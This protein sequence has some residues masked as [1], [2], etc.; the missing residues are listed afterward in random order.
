MAVGYKN[1]PTRLDAVPFYY[2]RITEDQ[3][4]FFPNPPRDINGFKNNNQ[5][6]WQMLPDSIVLNA[7]NN[8]RFDQTLLDT[9]TSGPLALQ[10]PFFVFGEGDLHFSLAAGPK[11]VVV[12]KWTHRF[13]NAAGEPLLDGD[14]NA[15]EISGSTAFIA[16]AQTG[17]LD[18]DY[19]LSELSRKIEVYPYQVPGELAAKLREINLDLTQMRIGI[20]LDLSIEAFNSAV[21]LNPVISNGR[22]INYQ[23]AL[24]VTD[25]AEGVPLA[26]GDFIPQGPTGFTANANTPVLP[27][28]G[29]DI[30][31]IGQANRR[32]SGNFDA[33]RADKRILIR[34]NGAVL[35]GLLYNVPANDRLYLYTTDDLG[36]LTIKRNDVTR[37]QVAATRSSA[38]TTLGGIRTYR[39]EFTRISISAGAAQTI[40]IDS[41]DPNVSIE[42][43]GRA[44]GDAPEDTTLS[45]VSYSSPS[46]TF[47]QGTQGSQEKLGLLRPDPDYVRPPGT[48][49]AQHKASTDGQLLVAARRETP[50]GRSNL[51]T[52]SDRYTIPEITDP[53]TFTMPADL[54]RQTI[55][56]Y[57]TGNAGGLSH[58]VAD[59]GIVI[60]EAG[61]YTVEAQDSF[62]FVSASITDDASPVQLGFVLFHWRTDAQGNDII[63]GD[64]WIDSY[65]L[66]KVRGAELAPL[67]RAVD[68]ICEVGD[69]FNLLFGFKSL[70]VGD[71]LIFTSRN[72][73]VP[74]TRIPDVDRR[75]KITKK[76]F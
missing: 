56:I 37:A 47:K 1:I 71:D 23:P 42:L 48:T 29:K 34:K 2:Q 27:S 21:D 49:E 50:E 66:A 76:Q 33:S 7:A 4:V 3:H 28:A 26:Q 11:L 20:K 64:T 67:A 9:D 36:V 68:I 45:N 39:Y 57:P 13:L 16:I 54:E 41:S 52:R 5:V 65:Q 74:G 55:F 17:I 40:E 6:F 8:H 18:I 30:L 73:F 25:F 10:T 35:D 59:K 38:T 70:T 75:M 12:H 53:M 15:I 72:T 46:V 63:V 44:I 60:D 24:P 43:Q 61:T 32:F 14:G 51:V 69:W 19:P 31:V 58:P 62:Q 22:I